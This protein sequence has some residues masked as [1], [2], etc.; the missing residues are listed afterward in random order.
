[1]LLRN[2]TRVYWLFSDAEKMQ[3][4][5]RLYLSV[6]TFD[7]III[8]PVYG[9]VRYSENSFIALIHWASGWVEKVVGMLH[10]GQ[11]QSYVFLGT[12]PASFISVFFKMLRYDS[13]SKKRR[14][15]AWDSNLGPQDGRRRR[16]HWAVD[17]SFQCDVFYLSSQVWMLS[18]WMKNEMRKFE[19]RY[20][21]TASCWCL[22][23][24]LLLVYFKW[25]VRERENRSLWER[26]KE[27]K[28]ERAGCNR[29]KGIDKAKKRERIVVVLEREILCWQQV[30]VVYLL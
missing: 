24:C 22:L 9:D 23:A 10:Q 8:H 5:F 14:W 30:S 1:M 6:K 12:N 18:S 3:K 11:S 28:K 7:M 13:Q 16:I 4:I 27:R 21:F 29:K 20:S 19:R 26:K 25:R 17:A 15:T 2:G